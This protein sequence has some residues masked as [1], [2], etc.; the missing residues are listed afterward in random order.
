MTRLRS[1]Y[2]IEV[3][4]HR[5][6]A[7]FLC[8]LL[9]CTLALASICPAASAIDVECSEAENIS[10]EERIS[11]DFLYEYIQDGKYTQ[12]LKIPTYEWIPIQ[13][14]GKEGKNYRG[15]VIFVHG[16]TMHGRRYDKLAKIL[17]ANNFYGIAYDMYGFGRNFFTDKRPLVDGIRSKRRIHYGRSHKRLVELV[18][19]VREEYPR[20]PICLL[21]ESLGATPCLK[22]AV[23]SRDLIDGIILSAP[24]VQINPILF[25]HPMSAMEATLP[26]MVSPHMN[27]RLNHFV[28]SLLSRDRDVK[29]DIKSDTEIRRRVTWIDLLRTQ[30]YVAKALIHGPRVKK[31]PPLLFMVGGKDLVVLPT[32]A[33]LL[34]S[35]I[36]SD[37]KKYVKLEKRSHLLTETSAIK[38]DT[39]SAIFNWFDET[40]PFKKE[41]RSDILISSPADPA[42]ES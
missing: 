1:R 12:S 3:P 5:Q 26:V 21:G 27:M 22:M 18:S 25:V 11:G 30:G 29:D 19:M 9:V 33:L 23:E 24:A 38:P 15:I 10:I 13:K 14:E 37:Q 8:L 40:E 42:A 16:F 36:K 35:S 2:R 20:T 4:G 6:A 17:A 41:N 7:I 39:V 34:Y 32:D 28:N 31:D